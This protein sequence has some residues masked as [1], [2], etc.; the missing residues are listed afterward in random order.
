MAT[1]THEKV[2]LESSADSPV[3]AVS[4]EIAVFPQYVTKEP[5]TITMN[6]WEFPMQSRNFEVTLPDGQKLFHVNLIY[7]GGLKAH[8]QITDVKTDAVILTIRRTW[9]KLQFTWRFEDVNGQK[10]L[11]WHQ[12]DWIPTVLGNRAITS[13]TNTSD[14]SPVELV[15]HGNWH[16]R[17]ATIENHATGEVIASVK[18]EIFTWRS[19]RG[20]RDYEVSVSAGV[21]LAIVTG[22]I[23]C[24]DIGSSG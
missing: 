5:T 19:Y 13:F 22:L 10:I 16:A 4:S 8:W 12:N 1:T 15:T 23:F 17:H 14:Q 7:E 3:S 20:R 18:S 11:D 24:L 21:D 2:V 9:L 6:E